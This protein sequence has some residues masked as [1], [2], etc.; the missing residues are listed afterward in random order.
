MGMVRRH[1]SDDLTA[2]EDRDWSFRKTGPRG[3]ERCV[4]L[5]NIF[6]KDHQ[7]IKR[8]LSL[9]DWSV[10]LGEHSLHSIGRQLREAC[11]MCGLS[12]ADSPSILSA[13]LVSMEP[14]GSFVVM[15]GENVHFSPNASISDIIHLHKDGQLKC[16][17]Y[18]V[19]F[20]T[21]DRIIL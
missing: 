3:T 5:T 8:S 18:A 9:S 15:P 21:H 16:T 19:L 6:N 12:A 11:R 7:F 2:V 13:C 10:L 4:S 14:Q 20:L 1:Y 17:Y